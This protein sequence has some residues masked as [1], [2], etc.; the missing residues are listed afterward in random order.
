MQCVHCQSRRIEVICE[1]PT[2]YFCLCL[3]CNKTFVVFKGRDYEGTLHL[4]ALR[5][6]Q[7]LHRKQAGILPPVPMFKLRQTFPGV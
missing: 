5:E 2:F 1:Y 3:A 4:Q 7:Y 6:Y